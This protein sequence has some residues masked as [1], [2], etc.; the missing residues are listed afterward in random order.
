MRQR[1]FIALS[2]LGWVLVGMGI[3]CAGMAGWALLERSGRLSCN[4]EGVRLQAQV[5]VLA[6]ALETQNRGIQATV[7]AGAAAQEEVGR[8]IQAARRLEQAS[9]GM[10]AHAR[11]VLAKPAPK[12]PDGKDVDC[13]DAWGEIESRVKP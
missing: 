2:P 10:V 8:L 12:R 7:D 13:R 11:G 1:G 3:L 6:T 4:V 9:A 5:S